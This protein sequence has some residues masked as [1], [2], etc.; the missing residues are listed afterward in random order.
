MVINASTVKF[1][2]TK[3]A[4]V[5]RACAKM[6]LA[7]AVV[8]IFVELASIVWYR[9]LIGFCDVIVLNTITLGITID[10]IAVYN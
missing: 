3:R 1:A 10:K 7:H 4:L 2:E 6:V 5:P 9:N 8:N